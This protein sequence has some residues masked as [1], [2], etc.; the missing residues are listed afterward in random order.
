MYG[1]VHFRRKK[2]STFSIRTSCFSF[3][4]TLMLILRIALS[5]CWKCSAFAE[6]LMK[7]MLMCLKERLE[8]SRHFENA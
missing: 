1:Y 2:D 3:L 6:T 4:S 5:G 7:V 8:R